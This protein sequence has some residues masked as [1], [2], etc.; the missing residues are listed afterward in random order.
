MTHC[1]AVQGEQNLTPSDAAHQA[2]GNM[3]AFWESPPV[4]EVSYRG[5]TFLQA[6]CKAVMD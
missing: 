3:P 6:F 4:R 2:F 1:H 5:L